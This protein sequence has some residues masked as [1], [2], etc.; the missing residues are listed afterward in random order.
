MTDAHWDGD[1]LVVHR[2]LL[3]KAAGIC[4]PETEMRVL[5]ILRM[6]TTHD[7]SGVKRPDQRIHMEIGEGPYDLTPADSA[8]L[9]TALNGTREPQLPLY[10]EL[11]SRG[12]TITF[13]LQ[14]TMDLATG[15]RD[16]SHYV[17]VLG[18]K[19]GPMILDAQKANALKRVLDRTFA[20]LADQAGA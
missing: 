15:V 6:V 2:E 12:T 3:E 8:Y 7:P 14:P 1:T 9:I 10:S 5:S 19:D 18:D 17:V 11:Q 16:L 20:S 4:P 13:H